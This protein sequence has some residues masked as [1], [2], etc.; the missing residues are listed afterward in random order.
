M[1]NVAR[2]TGWSV[3]QWGKEKSQAYGVDGMRHEID[4][5]E[6]RVHE[7]GDGDAHAAG[8]TF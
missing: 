1:K 5:E 2:E 8:K 7:L 4:G 3:E 6:G